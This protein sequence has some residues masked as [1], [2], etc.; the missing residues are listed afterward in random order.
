MKTGIHKIFFVLLMLCAFN[1][2]LQAQ[3]AD[4]SAGDKT[5]IHFKLG[6][7]VNSR[8][9][10]YG[11]TDSLK[12]SGFYPSAEIWLGDHF[13]VSASPV[14][15]NNSINSFEYAGT[16]ASAGFQFYKQDQYIIGI[17]ATRPIYKTGIALPQS[18]LKG[19]VS[20]SYSWLNKIINVNLGA[21]LKFSDKTD[22]GLNGG[23]DHLIRNEWKDGSVLVIDPSAYVYAGTQQFT[24]TYLNKTPGVLIFPGTTQTVSEDVKNFTVLAYEFSVPMVYSKGGLQL[25]INPAYIIPQHLITV[26]GRPDI[27]ERGKEMFYITAGLRYSF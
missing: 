8:L 20:G 26:E 23:L 15:V 6:A 5:K 19:Q 27:T 12:S 11:R 7:F 14:F 9:N 24:K 3:L 21:D 18:A 25:I 16:I 1:T 10:L 22:Y 2:Q 4:S 13:Y 17:T